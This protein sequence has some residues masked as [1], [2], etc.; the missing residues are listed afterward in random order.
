MFIVL[1]SSGTMVAIMLLGFFLRKREIFS[2]EA[3]SMVSWLV[4]HVTLPCMVIAKYSEFEIDYSL[5]FFVLLGIL[6]N[7]STLC[8]GYLMSIGKKKTD[9]AFSMLNLSG[10]NIG[11]FT[12]PF[13]QTF[14]NPEG[15]VAICMLDTGNSIMCTGGNYAITSSL[16]SSTEKQTIS[17][18]LKKLFTSVPFDTYLIMLILACL[19]IRVP[20]VLSQ[21][22][23]TIGNANT[24]LAMLM[25]GL[26]FNPN[27]K[28]RDAF[29]ASRIL[30][31]RYI[32]LGLLAT[33]LFHMLPY[34]LPMRQAVCL[35]LDSPL[36]VLCPVFT[37]RLGGNA[38]L[39]SVINSCAFLLSTVL[40]TILLLLFQL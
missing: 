3:F 5:L 27:I 39:S 15:V 32:F 4:M 20:A 11:T 10:F 17:G 14:L 24:F 25:I 9:R 12:L 22:A 31:F 36:S 13:A 28:I 30:V 38:E 2:K 29:S 8:A 16:C 21:A 26:G 7:L 33:V 19:H 23:F 40:I 6:V 35:V 34:S 18:F 1:T 37:G